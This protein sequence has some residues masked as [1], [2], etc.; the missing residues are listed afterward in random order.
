MAQ[1]TGVESWPE[2]EESERGDRRVIFG[3]SLSWQSRKQMST[4]KTAYSGWERVMK[5]ERV[6]GIPSPCPL[7]FLFHHHHPSSLC[8]PLHTSPLNNL[9]LLL[10]PVLFFRL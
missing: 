10:C 6:L 1:L 4:L 3:T 9:F 7:F 8:T 5:F 2:S